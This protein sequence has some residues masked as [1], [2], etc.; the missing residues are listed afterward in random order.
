MSAPP[1]KSE[2]LS[3]TLILSELKNGFW[4]WDDTRQMNLAMRATT[5]RDAFLEAIEYYQERL[6]RVEAEHRTLSKAVDAFVQ[7]VR[8][9]QD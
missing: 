6:L 4:L 2:Q 5:E 7:Q 9:E 8:P 3:P 1:I